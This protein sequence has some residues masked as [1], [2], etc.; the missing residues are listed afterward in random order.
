MDTSRHRMP[1]NLYSLPAASSAAISSKEPGFFRL[2]DLCPGQW[3]DEIH[4]ALKYYNRLHDRYPPYKALSYVT[5]NLETAL[6]HLREQENRVTLWIDALCI[7]QSNTEERSSQVAQMREIYSNASE[8]I[9]FLVGTLDASAAIDAWKASPLKTPCLSCS[10]LFEFLAD[11]PQDHLTQLSEALRRTLLVSWWDRIWV[12][13]E[14]VVAKQL[15]VRYGYSSYIPTSDLKVFNLFSRVSNLDHF[16]ENWRRS[17][18]TD[19]LSLM[20]YF[21]HRKASD[22]RDRVYA[23]LGLCNQT[24]AIRPNYRLDV[25]EVFMAPIIETIRNTKSLSVL[26]GDHSRKTRR[27]IPSW[28]PDWSTELDENQRQR[29][30]LSSL[31]NANGQRNLPKYGLI[32]HSGHSLAVHGI[33]IAKVTKIAEPLYASSDRNSTVEVLKRWREMAM[34][35]PGAYFR[36]NSAKENFLKTILSDAA[37]FKFASLK[38]L[39]T[40][41]TKALLWWLDRTISP[42]S[43][44]QDED[45][46]RSHINT[47]FGHFG[48][49]TDIMRLSAT[50]RTL[51]SNKPDHT[52]WNL[53]KFE[54]VGLG[55][56]LI[57]E[58]DEIHILPGSNLPLVLRP[59]DFCDSHGHSR[60]VRKY[61]LVGDCFLQGVM[62]GELGSPGGT[63]LDYLD[64]LT[65]LSYGYWKGFGHTRSILDRQFSKFMSSSGSDIPSTEWRFSEKGMSFEAGR[66]FASPGDYHSALFG[67]VETQP[68]DLVA[69]EIV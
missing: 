56:M 5:A 59:V 16:R 42:N 27:D 30:T 12:V 4:C 53:A 23:L 49:F 11:F 48:H 21:G 24:T 15:T 26:Y 2:I 14:A 40:K 55:P 57:K 9:I 68:G 3:D 43:R 20:R 51:F 33:K 36:K 6:K 13:Q 28:V 32:H 17:Q 19:L 31:F 52:N 67:Y 34:T 39:D 54:S 45:R 37:Y 50:N 41:N 47:R 18:E 65:K 61:Q 35:T 66:Y 1:N 10:D 58:G 63:I 60:L 7:D 29:A 8:V 69:L 62:D 25:K 64:Y 44:E 46:Y 38:R 22:D